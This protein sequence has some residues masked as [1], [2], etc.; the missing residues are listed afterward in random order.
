[1]VTA[2]FTVTL[3]TPA[4]FVVTVDYEVNSGVGNTGAVAGTDFVDT[5]GTLTYQ[6]GETTKNYTVQVV[7]DTDIELDEVFSTLISNANVPISVNGSIGHILDDD[8]FKVYLPSVI[9]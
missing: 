3:S 1:M 6:P 8:N 7:G 5:A 9:K 2:V 4:T